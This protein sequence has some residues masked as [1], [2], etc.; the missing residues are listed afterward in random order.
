MKSTDFF[1]ILLA[2]FIPK[3]TFGRLKVIKNKTLISLS[4]FGIILVLTSAILILLI[5]EA[6]PKYILFY[7][8]GVISNVLISGVFVS[9]IASKLLNKKINLKEGVSIA[10]V[11]SLVLIILPILQYTLN[12]QKSI[13]IGNLNIIYSLLISIAISKFHNIPIKKTFLIGIL[14]FVF[15]GTFYLSCF[16]IGL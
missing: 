7:N 2:P 3:W 10:S 16:G 15:K 12:V 8:F 4:S 9:V 13:P 5:K 14:L 1:L 6:K 11:S